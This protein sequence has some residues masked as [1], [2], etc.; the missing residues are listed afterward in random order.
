VDA[1]AGTS[2]DIEAANFAFDHGGMF[3]ALDFDSG[4]RVDFI[5]RKDREFS[6]REFE[7]R[8]KFVLSGVEVSIASPEDLIVAKLEWAKEGQSER[9]IEDAA[10]IL[11]AQREKLDLA[12][13]EDWVQQLALGA[14]WQE[15][16]RR[17]R[18]YPPR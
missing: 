3:N 9:Q 11:V 13:V 10:G 6:R 5:M 17:V 8:R 14:Q 18:L 2:I 7:R 4:W 15:A 12:Y 1:L 16:L